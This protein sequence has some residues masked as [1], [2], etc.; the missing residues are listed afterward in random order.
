MLPNLYHSTLFSAVGRP[1]LFRMDAEKAHH[2]AISAL[3]HGMVPA[4]SIEADH[5]LSVNL[6]SL[7]L[8]HPVGLA[9]GFDKNAE[10]I[11]N[12]S[13]LGFSF[14]ETGTVTPKAQPG[15]P[16]P[17]LFRLEKDK[18][19]I[20]RLGFN[21]KG[22]ESYLQNLTAR[23]HMQPQVRLGV[24]IGKNK[25]S[26]DAVADYLT[27]YEKLH[28]KADYI[29]VNISSPNTPGLR[30]LQEKEAI[31]SLL[32]A[33]EHARDKANS[34]T[35]M[36]V[37]IAPDMDESSL[38]AVAD[39]CIKASMDGLIV[40]NTTISRPD[41]V[42]HRHKTETGGLSGA[43]LKA[44]A[45]EALR[46]TYKHVGNSL[47]LIGVGGIV[48]GQDAVEKIRLGA[49]AVQLYSGLIYK[50]FALVKECVDALEK[51]LKA[52][53]ASTIADIIGIDA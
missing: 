34:S 21:N 12:L 49:T 27:C 37:K 36:F 7:H 14:I 2:L 39:A 11:R 15:N 33:L 26:E 44:A 47:P 48:N 6:G 53:Q 38:K 28:D 4:Q 1:L 25:T 29:T 45:N 20:N 24:N 3:K 19:I 30:D 32:A 51:E 52:N 13:Q 46:L 10:C 8:Q 5:S 43:P 9:A 40:S 35:P 17:R 22:L 42:Q 31:T 23:N 18:A 16:K 41:S 50:G